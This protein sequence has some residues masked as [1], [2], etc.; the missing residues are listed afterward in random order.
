MTRRSPRFLSYV[1]RSSVICG[2]ISG[3]P[4]CNPVREGL[5]T[6]LQ[7]DAGSVRVF[8]ETCVGALRNV[9]LGHIIH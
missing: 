5:P 7:L 2:V 4:F 1:H 9:F 6:I 8:P 3:Q